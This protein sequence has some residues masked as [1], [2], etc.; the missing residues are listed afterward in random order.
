MALVLENGGILHRGDTSSLARG[1]GGF[2]TWA[3]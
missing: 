2:N 1:G 3:L